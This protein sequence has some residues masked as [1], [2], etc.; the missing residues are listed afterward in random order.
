MP[1][2]EALTLSICV[3]GTCSGRRNDTVGQDKAT[4]SVLVSSQNSRNCGRQPVALS[5]PMSLLGPALTVVPFSPSLY[6]D[7]CEELH[8]WMLVLL[9]RSSDI[10]VAD[11]RV[12]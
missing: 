8:C 11:S 12:N 6:I 7:R 2:K 4:S 5:V 10:L 3:T 1:S 9:K